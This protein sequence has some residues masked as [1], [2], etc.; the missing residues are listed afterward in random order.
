MDFDGCYD[1]D[2]ADGEKKAMT[3]A[4]TVTAAAAKKRRRQE[5]RRKKKGGRRPRANR[6]RAWAPAVAAGSSALLGQMGGSGR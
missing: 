5:G 2:G 1:G 6:Q 4:P 3:R